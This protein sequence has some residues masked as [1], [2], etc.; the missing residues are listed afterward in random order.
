MVQLRSANPRPGLD[1]LAVA[2]AP[3]PVVVSASHRL[4]AREIASGGRGPVHGATARFNN[5][6]GVSHVVDEVAPGGNLVCMHYGP[7]FVAG[8][9]EVLSRQ[10]VQVAAPMLLAEF[11]ERGRLKWSEDSAG[12][13]AR[14][15]SNFFRR[16][17]E[18]DARVRGRIAAAGYGGRAREES[19][20][21]SVR[22]SH[23]AAL[24]GMSGILSAELERLD[25]MPAENR[26]QAGPS[27]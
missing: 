23:L 21:E 13:L 17:E 8:R 10:E 22:A 1:E 24:G 20:G 18:N 4:T 12:A 6:C 19:V 11:E 7:P 26:S 15:L 5:G 16:C 2:A 3:A 14:S 25:R 27:A 9:T